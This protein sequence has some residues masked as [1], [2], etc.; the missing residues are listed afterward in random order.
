MSNKKQ[1]KKLVEVEDNVVIKRIDNI[2]GEV[3]EEEKYH[4]L[5][6]DAGLNR[7][8]D[9]IGDLSD[10]GFTFIAIGEGVVAPANGDTALGTEQKREAAIVSKPA[11]NQVKYE[12]LFTFGSGESFN[13]TEAGLFDLAVAGTMLN[14]LTFPAKAVDFNTDLSVI[15]TI[16]VTRI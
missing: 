16:F 13:I 15:I 12:K 11:S 5:I 1:E 3:L 10:A 6:V 8:A 14:R 7:V 9:L 4:N 2:T